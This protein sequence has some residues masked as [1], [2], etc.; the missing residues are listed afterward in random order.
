[1][2]KIQSD[3]LTYL[4]NLK[5]SLNKVK[6]D[7]IE[8]EQLAEVI[9]DI[10]LLVPVV[11]AFSA[12]KST[13]L[14]TFLGNDYLP[15]GITPETALATEIRFAR[16]TEHIEAV[17]SDGSFD[18]FNLDE[19]S[20]L[21]ALASKYKFCRVYINSQQLSEIEPLVLVD[22]PGFESPLDLHNQ[23]IMEYINRGVH[24]IVLT[25]VEDGTLTRS[26]VR[27]LEDIQAYQRDFSFF[28]SKSDLRPEEDVLRVKENLEDVIE[29]ELDLEK[30]VVPINTVDEGHG[31][32]LALSTIDPESLFS[33]M[34]KSEL[35]EN[36]QDICESINIRVAT[37]KRSS[38]ENDQVMNEL[39]D[40]LNKVLTKKK[41]MIA[42]IKK[43]G[44]SGQVNK[45]A[46]DVGLAL[47]NGVNELVQSLKMGGSTAVSRVISEI[48]KHAL[49]PSIN[50]TMQEI[51]E[52][53]VKDFSVQLSSINKG[54]DGLSGEFIDHIGT[55]TASMLAKTTA[56]LGSFLAKKGGGNIII[57]GITSVLA[58]TTE[59][60]N[61]LVGL[62]TYFLPDVISLFFKGNK[63]KQLRDKIL[64]EVI[65][66]ITSK[67]RSK[68]PDL[69]NQ[70]VEA[71]IIEIGNAF[72]EKISIKKKLVET[73]QKQI[74]EQKNSIDQEIEKLIT[75]LAEVKSLAI[76][77]L[78]NS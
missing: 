58:I 62:L 36:F 18:Q 48:T 43:Q 21:G 25:S 69:L 71:L 73:Q 31:L 59:I 27:Q 72:E 53:L 41:E 34:F 46:K 19:I 10:E 49:I 35:I 56:G 12:G 3:F 54:I 9:Q 37:L 40:G 65:P 68:L 38:E 6:L 52:D 39:E 55:Q 63:D 75:V 60:L 61:P 77:T 15:T 66:G 76:L 28:L 13:L 23:A 1:M 45:I 4:D 78:F 50:S 74:S 64:H 16:S 70:Q 14:N 24:Y 57:K 7:V 33:L 30:K 11:G 22:M 47:A 2:L 29:E 44:T 8:Q 17:K 42:D 20:K 67:L 51:S 5:D 32:K 26:M